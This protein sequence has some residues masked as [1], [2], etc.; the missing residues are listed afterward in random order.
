P[1]RMPGREGGRRPRALA[2]PCI[3]QR[4]VK[5]SPLQGARI[6]ATVANGGSQMRPYLIDKRQTADLATVD[7]TQPKEARHPINAQVA[8]ALQDMMFSRG[9]NGT[10]RKA[11]LPGFPVGGQT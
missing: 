4:E 9:Q 8:G 11:Q 3:G 10:P 2:Q 7:T 5:M 1:G 6:A